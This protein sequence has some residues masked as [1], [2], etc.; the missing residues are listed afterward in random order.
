MT[1]TGKCLSTS[2]RI[3]FFKR[4]LKTI[5]AQFCQLHPFL[6]RRSGWMVALL[7]LGL[8]S[9][10]GPLTL[11]TAQPWGTKNRYMLPLDLGDDWQTNVI[12]TNREE[13]QANLLSAY[14]SIADRNQLAE[15][16]TDGIESVD[17]LNH[18]KVQALFGLGQVA[19]GP[20]PSNWYTTEDATQITGLRINLPPPDCQQFPSNCNDLIAL[21]T[22]DGFNLQPRVSIPFDGAIDLTTVTSDS[23]F[24]VDTSGEKIGIN[25]LVWDPA[26]NTLHFEPEQLL[27]QRMTHAI[28]VTRDILDTDGKNIKATDAF[29]D[30]LDE[31]C[32]DAA[33]CRYQSELRAAV[34]AALQHGV[35]PGH[36]MSA[37]VFTT[38]SS[39]SVMEKIRDQIKSS[40]APQAADFLIGANGERAVFNLSQVSSIVWRQQ[41]LDAPPAFTNVNVNLALYRAVPGA[42]GQVAFGRYQSPQYL[43]GHNTIPAIGTL[44]GV[45]TVTGVETV[46]FTLVLPSG[47]KPAAGWPI[48]LIGN[49]RG[50]S[51]DGVPSLSTAAKLTQHGLAVLTVN[52]VGRGFGPLGTL[53]VNRTGVPAVILPSGGRGKD[54]NSDRT[55]EANEGDIALTPYAIFGFR[56]AGRQTVADLMELARVI[57]AGVDVDG[58]GQGDLDGSRLYGWGLSFGANYISQLTILDSSVRATV[59]VSFGGPIIDSW[60]MGIVTR[61]L[62]AALLSSRVPSLINLPNNEF[63]DNLPF[64]DMAPVVNQVAGA[65]PIQEFFD[66]HEWAGQVGNIQSY[67]RHIKRDPLAGQSPKKVIGLFGK[68]DQSGPNPTSSGVIRSAGLEDVTTFYRN[69]LAFLENPLTPKNPHTFVQLITDPNMSQIALGALE[70]GAVFLETDGQQIIHPEPARFFEVP[71][72]LPLPEGLN[73]IP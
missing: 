37:S 63:N 45:P 55:I 71:I 11:T 52:A 21:S 56:D 54:A 57:Q 27:K 5:E 41:T 53:T 13:Q 34:D 40:P 9:V 72:V 28:I 44:Y 2:T 60:R 4:T 43:D 19:D 25:Q 3:H 36:V 15:E 23:L 67:A 70:Q 50:Q 31:T 73:Y 42:I 64:R 38:L 18:E 16:S 65:M 61:P 49:G 46:Y 1:V 51:K 32:G 10:A 22:L 59:L 26:T 14:M 30:F 7:F 8:S 48:V 66:R 69:D 29:R 17:A 58:D 35:P 47:T 20:F 24:L 6:R 62:A 68:G 12:I 39:T 33:S